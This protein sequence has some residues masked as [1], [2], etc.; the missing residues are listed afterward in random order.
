MIRA[1]SRPIGGSQLARNALAGALPQWYGRRLS[2]ATAW[3]NAASQVAA[4]FEHRTWL[5]DL[6]PAFAPTGLAADRLR[7][8]SQ[9]GGL[10]VTGGQQP[11]L[12][13]GPLYVLHKAVTLLEMADAHAA[14]TGRPVAPVFWAATD[15]ADLVEAN[16][17]SV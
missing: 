1:I 7:A 6:L 8:A 12:F 2:D 16:H 9:S 10:V 15:D 5:D 13:G 3:E 17:V 11:G 4:D 14:L